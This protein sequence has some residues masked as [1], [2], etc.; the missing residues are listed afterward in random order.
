MWFLLI[1]TGSLQRRAVNVPV[2]AA[3]DVDGGAGVVALPADAGLALHGEVN[4]PEP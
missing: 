1:V 3:R 4:L 2:L